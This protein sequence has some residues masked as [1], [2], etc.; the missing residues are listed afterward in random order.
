MHYRSWCR[1]GQLQ[2]N[3]NF[4]SKLSLKKDIKIPEAEKLLGG[5]FRILVVPC[6]SERYVNKQKFQSGKGE[7][8]DTVKF[9]SCERESIFSSL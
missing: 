1:R 8:T 4:R 6:R 7:A 2:F 9:M 3:D 5:S